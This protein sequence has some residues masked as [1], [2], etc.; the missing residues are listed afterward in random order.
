MQ[1][2]TTSTDF[3]PS[4]RRRTQSQNSMNKSREKQLMIEKKL[5]SGWIEHKTNGYANI[6]PKDFPHEYF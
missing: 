2:N 3:I 6:S 1:T 5:L 4:E